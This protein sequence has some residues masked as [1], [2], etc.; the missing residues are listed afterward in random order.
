MKL[1][2][3]SQLA[4][5][6]I[7]TL[8]LSLT[9]VGVANAASATGT[10]TISITTNSNFDDSVSDGFSEDENE[11]AMY[12]LL[13]YYANIPDSVLENGDAALLDWQK[14]NPVPATRASVLGCIGAVTWLIVSNVVGVAKIL[15]IKK[16]N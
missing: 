16:I 4:T 1:R 7:C 10:G 8:A 9:A 3:I 15:K 11:Q 12:Q 5:A 2:K 14:R 13:N 6:C